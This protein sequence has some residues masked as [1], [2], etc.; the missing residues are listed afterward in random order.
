MDTSSLKTYGMAVRWSHEIIFP[1]REPLKIYIT[2]CQLQLLQQMILETPDIQLTK[3]LNQHL[4]KEKN[5]KQLLPPHTYIRQILLTDKTMDVTKEDNLVISFL[6]SSLFFFFYQFYF[7]FTSMN[8][9]L[10]GVVLELLKMGNP[11]NKLRRTL[12]SRKTSATV[13]WKIGRKYY[14][15]SVSRASVVHAMEASSFATT[16]SHHIST[17]HFNVSQIQSMGSV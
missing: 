10:Q 1:T 12:Q 14:C 9:P 4:E 5:T 15:R 16:A 6:S 2:L 7:S 13:S 8:K 11:A 17:I 3:L